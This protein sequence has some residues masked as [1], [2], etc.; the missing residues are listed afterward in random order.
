MPDIHQVLRDSVSQHAV[1]EA[2]GRVHRLRGS[3]SDP[4]DSVTQ[5]RFFWPI[6]A[7]W[8]GQLCISTDTRT[9]QFARI[10]FC[11]LNFFFNGGLHFVCLLKFLIFLLIPFYGILRKYQSA[12]DRKF[13]K[14][15][16]LTR[17]LE[18]QWSHTQMLMGAGSMG[19]HRCGQAGKCKTHSRA[20]ERPGGISDTYCRRRI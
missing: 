1:E 4:L 18:K 16:P 14:L 6:C 7:L 20:R 9:W 8:M 5:V 3:F 15:V 2:T 17:S 10:I 13:R 11:L 12:T 19:E